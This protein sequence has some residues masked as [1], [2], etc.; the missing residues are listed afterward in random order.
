MRVRE[1]DTWLEQ[2]PENATPF[3]LL[4]LVIFSFNHLLKCK[5]RS[6]S[7]LRRFSDDSKLWST[8]SSH[9]WT[10]AIVLYEKHCTSCVRRIYLVFIFWNLSDFYLLSSYAVCILQKGTAAPVYHTWLNERGLPLG[11]TYLPISVL[12]ESVT[13]VILTSNWLVAWI[14]FL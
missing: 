8:K 2:V 6:F 14:G 5:I 4:V 7:A 11:D 13:G 9:S 1:I 12:D 3:H 10:L